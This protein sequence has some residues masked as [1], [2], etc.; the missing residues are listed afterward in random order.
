MNEPTNI[1]LSEEAHAILDRW[2][3]EGHFHEQ[4]D[5]YKFAVAYA[6]SLQRDPPEI[7]GKKNMYGVSTIDSD[8]SLALATKQLSNLKPDESVYRYIERLASW[9][10]CRLDKKISEVGELL[11]EDVFRELG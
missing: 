7:Q 2:K 10:I 8:G 11:L 6:L 5:A 3:D 4:R 9:G 1:G